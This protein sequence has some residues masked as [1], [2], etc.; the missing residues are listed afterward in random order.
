MDRSIA[1]SAGVIGTVSL[2][3]FTIFL[4]MGPIGVIDLGLSGFTS[5]TFDVALCLAFFL[6]H[7]GMIRK[8]FRGR[9]KNV[10]PEHYHG[11]LY[12]VAS[13]VTLLVLVVF[14]QRTSQV[15]VSLQGGSRLAARLVF[16]ATLAGFVWG[17]RSLRSFDGFGLRP[18]RARL[19]GSKVKAEPLTI[20]GPYRWIRHPLYLF[21][22]LLI[23]SCPDLSVDRI[24]FDVLMTGWIVVGTHLEERDLVDDF[25]DDYLEYQRRVPMLVPWS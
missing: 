23:W 9:L 2:L 16:F 19:R 6:Q 8:S 11:V 17:I 10:V 18:I 22:L 1:I 12:T 21:V 25:G 14:W 24:M 13:G 5:I 4:F 3:G 20:R 7:S 15:E